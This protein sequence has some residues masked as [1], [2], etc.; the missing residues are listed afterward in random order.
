MT[1]YFLK[2]FVFIIWEVAP[3]GNQGAGFVVGLVTDRRCRLP[4]APKRDAQCQPG[5]AFWG[6]AGVMASEALWCLPTA[7]GVCRQPAARRARFLSVH[8]VRAT[9]CCA[10]GGGSTE[11]GTS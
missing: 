11:R 4:G 3:T 8:A 7:Y 6:A 5:R 2:S 9:P 10:R 1:S